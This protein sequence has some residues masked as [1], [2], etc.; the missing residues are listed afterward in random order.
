MNAYDLDELDLKILREIISGNGIE[1][2]YTNLSRSVNKHRS[3]VIRRINF[4]IENEIISRPY[5]FPMGLIF[6]EYPLFIVVY[7]DLPKEAE[8]WMKSDPHIF[9][10]F[11]IIEENYNVLLFEYHKTVHSYQTWRERLTDE[12][13]IPSR[14]HREPSTSYYLS[15]NLVI[16][17]D[18]QAVLGLLEQEFRKERKKF[19]KIGNDEIDYTTFEL[20]KYV[21]QGKNGEI[22]YT[23]IN[24]NRLAQKLGRHRKTI[25]QHIKKLIEH[26]IIEFPRCH[27]LNYYAPKGFFLVFSML[28]IDDGLREEFS[29][30]I[31]ADPHVPLL[32]RVSSGKYS[33]GMLSV[34]WSADE[35]LE[36][37]R[38]YKE[39]LIGSQKVNILSPNAIIFLDQ[40]KIAKHIISKRIEQLKE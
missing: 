13:K 38:V 22:D 10:A 39:R 19:I 36:W 7:A 37:N 20:L 6:N 26:G 5:C 21:V 30:Q 32:Y 3:T 31:Q 4:L 9:A 23:R 12:K 34:H 40:I 15:N 11:H 1:L 27:F 29:T 2:N 25:E 17:H 35:L 14:A 8:P 28:E 24:E 18:I 33:H 16:K